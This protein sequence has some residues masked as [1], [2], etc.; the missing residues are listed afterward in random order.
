VFICIY[1]MKCIIQDLPYDVQFYIIEYIPQLKCILCNQTMYTFDNQIKYCSQYC[2]AVN[3]I[4]K[5]GENI[6]TD[7][8]LYIGTL[9]GLITRN[10]I[11]LLTA[12]INVMIT[13]HIFYTLYIIIYYTII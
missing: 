5:T 6:M 13:Y 8:S 2:N 7:I 4:C 12:I 3:T 11:L 9:R 1:K 10:M